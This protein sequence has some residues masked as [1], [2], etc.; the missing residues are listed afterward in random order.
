MEQIGQE[1]QYCPEKSRSWQ[2]NRAQERRE[3]KGSSCARLNVFVVFEG[4]FLNQFVVF[5]LILSKW[6]CRFLGG[7][8][9]SAALVR[10]LSGLGS[11]PISATFTHDN[12]I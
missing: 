3:G 9:A 1:S 2:Q 11:A 6:V 5:W 8:E 4:H 7:I 10:A 12:S